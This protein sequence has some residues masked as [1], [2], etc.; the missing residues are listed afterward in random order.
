[1]VFTIFVEVFASVESTFTTTDLLCLCLSNVNGNLA[2]PVLGE[3]CRTKSV[4]FLLKQWGSN[5]GS[6]DSDR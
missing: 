5:W 1:M 4:G 6:F 2:L 3:L